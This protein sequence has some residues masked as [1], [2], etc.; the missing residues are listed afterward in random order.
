M[1]KRPNCRLQRHCT[2][3]GRSDVRT[4]LGRPNRL[5]SEHACANRRRYRLRHDARR[6]C[7][8]ADV[9]DLSLMCEP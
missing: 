9:K 3:E 6:K 7:A 5:H 4:H 1:L 8:V 2:P